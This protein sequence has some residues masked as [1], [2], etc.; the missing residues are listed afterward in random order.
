MAIAV[1]DVNKGI[2]MQMLRTDGLFG[3]SSDDIESKA[4]EVHNL[5]VNGDNS[6]TLKMVG[7]YGRSD[8][9]NIA[10]FYNGF[11]HEKA[12]EKPSKGKKK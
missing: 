4:K 11:F 12:K 8:S 5:V 2:I 3:Y 6:P 10:V 7:G 1:T 9:G